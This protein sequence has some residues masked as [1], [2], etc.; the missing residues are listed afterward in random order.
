MILGERSGSRLTRFELGAGACRVARCT[1]SFLLAVRTGG[2]CRAVLF[3]LP[4]R[5]WVAL[6][7]HV[8]PLAV[9]AGGAHSA[10]VFY[11]PVR[12]GAALYAAVFPIA[13][14]AGVAHHAHVFPLAVGA[15]V[16]RRAAGFLLA[17]RAGVALRTVLFQLAVRARVAYRTVVLH[18][19][20]G[21]GAALR[22]VA[23][24][25]PVRASFLSHSSR[26]KKPNAHA[27]LRPPQTSWS[28]SWF[29]FR[30]L[31]I[32]DYRKCKNPVGSFVATDR[33]PTPVPSQLLTRPRRKSA[34]LA[35]QTHTLW[36]SSTPP[37]SRCEP[38][39]ARRARQRRAPRHINIWSVVSSNARRCRH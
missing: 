14:R 27:L 3:Q 20:V 17:V 34:P 12:T 19:A 28:E 31:T 21:A 13:V 6:H 8:F 5:T 23:F 35:F 39:G 7:A 36:S 26:A 30:P 1:V 18:L 9:R 29:F 2:A 33:R 37:R 4:M 24:L 15:G 38:I 32:S 11:L 10:L 16:A 22:A 25:P